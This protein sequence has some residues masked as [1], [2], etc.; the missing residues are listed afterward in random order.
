MKRSRLAFSAVL[1]LGLA[2]CGAHIRNPDTAVMPN[3]ALGSNGDPDV[4]ALNVAAYDFAH[5]I[6]DPAVGADAI[7]SLDYLGGIL[8]TSPRWNTT[9]AIIRLQMLKSRK[10]LRA[11]VGISETA[12]SQAVVNTMLALAPAL[13]ANDQAKVQQLLASPIFTAPPATVVANLGNIPVM[14]VVNNATTIAAGYALGV[15]F[16]G[17]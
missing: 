13:R 1:F 9:P 16:P 3:G 2:S 10:M 8:N 17:G 5:K 14:P 6:T 4:R 12:P 7:A 11:Y 15:P